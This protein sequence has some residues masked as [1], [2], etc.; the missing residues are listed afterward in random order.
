MGA[1]VGILRRIL[2]PRLIIP[3]VFGLVLL[4]VVLSLG[5][6]KRVGDAVATFSPGLAALFF[7]TIV[8]YEGL[9]GLQWVYF[10]RQ[11]KVPGTWREAVVAFVGGEA[12]E[13][14]P[15]GI[16]FMNYLLEREEGVSVAYSAVATL[17]GILLEVA[18]CMLYL[19]IVGLDSWTWLRPLIVGG[20]AVVFLATLIA[21]K[22]S[23]L[24]HLPRRLLRQRLVQWLS[25]QVRSSGKGAAR[26][27]GQ[28]R[29]LPGFLLTALYLPAG[30]TAYFI[31]MQ[32]LGVDQVSYWQALSAYLFALSSGLILPVP[33]EVGVAELTGLGALHALG[34]ETTTAVTVVLMFRLLLVISSILIAAVTFLLLRRE[35]AALLSEHPRQRPDAVGALSGAGAT[36]EG[37]TTG[38]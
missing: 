25:E 29:L 17:A 3:L 26:L 1:A 21:W 20:G 24:V 6:R 8:L 35:F 14:L 7:L 38:C 34:V 18:F 12:T 9:H 2:R 11:L 33:T 13:S 23:G 30:G 4:G 32:A 36:R 16:Y 31:I 22:L 15:I 10:L 5:D 37:P 27:L 19:A 28:H